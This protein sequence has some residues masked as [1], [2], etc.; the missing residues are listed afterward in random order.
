MRLI[1]IM[2]LVVATAAAAAA[3]PPKV[4]E[5]ARI[6]QD[7]KRRVDAY[8][9]LHKR[10]EKDAPPL[11][12]TADPGQIQASQDAMAERI[13][14]ARGAAKQGEIFTPEIAQLFRRLMSPE[15][16]GSQGKETK[17][18]LKEDAPPPKTVP[19]KVNARYPESAPLPTVPPNLLASLPQLPEDL[20]YRIVG[21]DLIL[22]DV[23]ANLIV[24][25]LPK[26]IR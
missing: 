9:E 23:H 4:N 11:K 22:R 19:L 6:L 5:D 12:K 25:Y 13:R 15:V 1:S 17:Q 26:A 3:Q 20:E 16:K 8:M 10:I 7:F 24:D 2:S 21:T 14:A 18:I